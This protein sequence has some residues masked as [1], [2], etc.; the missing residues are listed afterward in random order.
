[1]KERGYTKS[2]KMKDMGRIIIY[3]PLNFDAHS[4]VPAGRK[5]KQEN[6]IDAMHY[7]LS[8]LLVEVLNKKKQEQLEEQGFIPLHAITLNNIV[9]A[10]YTKALQIL[11]TGNV[12]VTNSLYQVGVISKGYRLTPEY[13]G[14]TKKVELVSTGINQRLKDFLTQEQLKQDLRLRKVNH[15]IEYFNNDLQIGLNEVHAFIEWYK[16]KMEKLRESASFTSNKKRDEAKARILNRVFYMKAVVKAFLRQDFQQKRDDAGRLYSPLTS[17]KKELRAFVTYEGKPLGSVD[18][19]ASQPYLLQILLKKEF[20][21]TT[22]TAGLSLHQIYKPLYQYLQKHGYITRVLQHLKNMQTDSFSSIKWQNDYYTY[23]MTAVKQN[24]MS[25]AYKSFA[26]RAET[27]KTMMLLLYDSYKYKQPPYYRAF[28]ELFP[29]LTALMDLIKLAGKN[30]LSGI[31]QSVEANIILERVTK[32]L[33]TANPTMPL[34]TIHDSICTTHENLEAVKEQ[35]KKTLTD[36]IGI[37][38]GLKI[39]KVTP[40]D[41][42]NNLDSIVTEDWQEL[43]NNVTKIQSEPLWLYSFDKPVIDV[44]LLYKQPSLYGKKLISSRFFSDEDL[45]KLFD[46]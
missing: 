14:A 45:Q 28:K 13:I 16:H 6:F 22:R 39:E 27:K 1:M 32:D 33:S 36:L 42:L 10:I 35:M 38:P 11:I 31:L 46:E 20:W 21:L 3:V 24:K 18:I 4:F 7:I 43:Y 34:F 12:I 5:D 41:V 30:V 17:L 25:Y 23:L 15:L 8:L 19:T 9:G 44:P 37:A 26:T 40:N 2:I 29:D